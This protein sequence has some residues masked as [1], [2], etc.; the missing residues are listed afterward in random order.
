M[1]LALAAAGADVALAARTNDEI[2]TLAEEIRG[3]GRKAEAVVTDVTEPDQCAR[4]IEETVSRLGGVNILV[5]NAGINIRKPVLEMTPEEFMSVLETNLFGYFLCARAAGQVMVEQQKGKVINISSIMGRVVLANQA[6]YSSA[7]GGVDQLTRALAVE[8]AQDGVQANGIA[9]TYFE[10]EL[11]RPL[12]E[13]PERREFITSRTPMGRW[14][15][16]HELAGAVVFLA[17]SASDYVTGET[18]LVDGGWTAW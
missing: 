17:S 1:A 7:K 3:L 14:G 16:P 13:D 15:K 5:N 2:D 8:W 9:P 18:I 6:A 11:T 4:L 10:T 12:F